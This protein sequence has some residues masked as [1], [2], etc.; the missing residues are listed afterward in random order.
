MTPGVAGGAGR[1]G[2]GQAKD[3]SE[4]AGGDPPKVKVRH[5]LAKTAL[6]TWRLIID[7]C[8]PDYTIAVLVFIK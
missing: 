8:R 4:R 6:E 1:Q 2:G 3:H 7:N 5:H